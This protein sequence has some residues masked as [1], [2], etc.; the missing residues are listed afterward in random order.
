MIRVVPI[1]EGRVVFANEQVVIAFDVILDYNTLDAHRK[2][3]FGKGIK[4]KNT[5]AEKR[6]T[7]VKLRCYKKILLAK[8]EGYLVILIGG[9]R[10]YKAT[11]LGILRKHG[12]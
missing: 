5:F 8:A 4:F 11:D 3:G 9:E 2:I 10:I 12:F 6:N 1:I 7:V